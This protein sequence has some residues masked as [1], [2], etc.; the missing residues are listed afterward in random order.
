M[1]VVQSLSKR[2]SAS[3]ALRPGG[4]RHPCLQHQKAQ[5]LAPSSAGNVPWI[6][7]Q[8]LNSEIVPFGEPRSSGSYIATQYP[9][10][11]IS[12][13]LFLFFRPAV[14]ISASRFVAPSDGSASNRLFGYGTVNFV[15]NPSNMDGAASSY[16]TASAAITSWESTLKM[17]CQC[18][19]RLETALTREA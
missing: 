16:E 8:F 10:L 17:R 2:C 14:K 18:T 7:S 9:E 19:G 5:P 12:A 11:S 13:S 1:K 4:V 3:M 6:G 15:E